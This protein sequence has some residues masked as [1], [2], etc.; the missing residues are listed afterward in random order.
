[1]LITIRILSMAAFKAWTCN[2]PWFGSIGLRA[3]CTHCIYIPVTSDRWQ[4]WQLKRTSTI[5]ASLI[6][7]EPSSGFLPA[8]SN[9]QRRLWLPKSQPATVVIGRM[10]AATV[11]IGRM[12]KP[13]AIGGMLAEQRLA[14]PSPCWS[15]PRRG[16]TPSPSSRR[17]LF[18]CTATCRPVCSLD[19]AVCLVP[20]EKGAI[21]EA[22][23]YN[24]LGRSKL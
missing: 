15:K 2:I 1:M 11:A 14:C 22:L 4:P 18:F 9:E 13:V 5:E 17:Q 12:L 20:I 7:M 3:A 19:G 21:T 16:M 10:L 6:N 23:A 8:L 24:A